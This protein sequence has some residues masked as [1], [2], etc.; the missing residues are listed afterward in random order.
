MQPTTQSNHGS[1]TILWLGRILSALAALFLLLDGVGKV[2]KPAAVV[3]ATVQLGYPESVI[4]SLGALVLICTVLYVLP[5]TSTLGA[6]LLTGFLGGAVASNLR[7]GSPL[8]SHVL[9]PVYIG[10][11]VWGGLYLRDER[12]RSLFPLQRRITR[13]H[14]G[15]PS[16]ERKRRSR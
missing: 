5:Q 4:S 14:A 7:V 12:L 16:E 10:L 6:V 2:M 11:L 13:R 15:G 3:E 9:F 1:K 8:L